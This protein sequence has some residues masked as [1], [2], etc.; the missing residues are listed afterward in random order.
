MVAALEA[1]AVALDGQVEAVVAV[2]H[3]NWEVLVALLLME[4]LEPMAW[5]VV[6][7]ALLEELEAATLVAHQAVQA[8]LVVTVMAAAAAVALVLSYCAGKK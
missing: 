5:I 3:F 8:A 2:V 4:L 1:A 6:I 7:V